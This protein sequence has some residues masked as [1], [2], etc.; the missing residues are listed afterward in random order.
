MVSGLNGNIIWSKAVADQPWN[1]ARISDI[2]GDA[3]N[4]VLVGTLFQT[5]Y[6][7]FLDGVDGTE[8]F[9]INYGEPVDAIA[10]VSDAIGDGSMEMIA[11]GRNGKVTCYS[12]GLDSSTTP[13]KIT[14]NF[15]AEPLYGA[16]PLSVD[17]TDTSTA[18][19]TTITSWQ[20]DFNNDGQIDSIEQNPSWIYTDDGSYTVVLT[21]SDGIRSDTEIKEDYITVAPTSME[22]R[23]I[24]GGLFTVKTAIKNS[25][26]APLENI[27]WTI[28]LSGGSIL[29]GKL[30]SGN[31][32]SLAADETV[33]IKSS[34]ILGLG[35]TTVIV[36]AETTT[37]ITATRS[38]SATILLFYIYM[39]PGGGQ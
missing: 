25:G 39:P 21:V 2:S 27:D 23:P 34:I 22:I 24:S 8:L 5:N 12:G 17:F 15:T 33:D 14:A 28:E 18:E 13:I 11:G 19:N 10:A 35:K 32:G 20:W 30:S 38:K 4:D 7:Y 36:N 26:D 1:V 37:G 6:C 9:S 16:K 31:I 3:I 29:L